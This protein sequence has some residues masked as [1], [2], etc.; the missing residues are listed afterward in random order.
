MT[1]E[2]AS[3]WT[4]PSLPLSPRLNF[5]D[6]EIE[7]FCSRY[8]KD[9]DF[10]FNLEEINAIEQG[11]GDQIANYDHLILESEKKIKEELAV[12]AGETA[13]PPPKMNKAQFS[14]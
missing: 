1:K 5:T 2:P 6:L 4:S 7:V 12:G 10:Q 13:E 3:P 11:L 9:G 14:M 8:D